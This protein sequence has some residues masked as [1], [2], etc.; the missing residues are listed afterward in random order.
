LGGAL[1]L[2]IEAAYGDQELMRRS[3]QL[4]DNRPGVSAVYKVGFTVGTPGTLGSIRV[5]FCSNNPVINAACTPP[6][7]FDVSGASL[8]SQAG[9]TG[10]AIGSGTTA[11]V[12]ILSRPP[13]ASTAQPVSYELAGVTNPSG[14][15]SY[16][17]RVQTFAA[18]DA[19]GPATDFGGLAF[20]INQ[21]LSI[22]AEVPPYLTFCT[23]VTIDSLD[24]AS[25]SGD[26]INFG[27]LSFR[28]ASRGQSQLLV[29]TNAANGYA[30]SAS[31]PTLT[32]G[33][34][35]IQALTAPDVSRPGTSQFGINLRA[36]VSPAVGADPNGLGSGSPTAGYAIPNFYRFL[37]GDTVAGSPVPDDYRRYTVSYVV[38]V[39]AGQPPGIY[40]STFTYICL[41][42]F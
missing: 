22:T 26:Y 11:N 14:E 19:S 33:N 30:I 29:A 28:R 4:A 1:L 16:Y 39:P 37:S 35:I 13:A 31:G 8:V 5:Q 25:A 9:E 2:V 42:N 23:A 3:L 36:N 34:N 17:A 7:G 10:F 27:E 12:L 21:V 24:C 41:A 38:N 20:S 15:G 6:A 18:A 32:S 40:V